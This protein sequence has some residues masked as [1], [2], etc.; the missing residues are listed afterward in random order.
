M[1][2]H[3]LSKRTGLTRKAIEYY[4]EKNLITCA[5]LDNGYR[6]FEKDQIPRLQKISV[7]RKFDLSTEQIRMILDGDEND[8]LQKL[9][10]LKKLR[11]SQEEKKAALLEQLGSRHNYAEINAALQAL[12]QGMSIAQRLL[13]A[14]PGY[15]GKYVCLH[16]A[17][18]LDEP[19]KTLEQQRAYGEILDFLDTLP[20]FEIPA[21]LQPFLDEGLG[22]LTA[23]QIQSLSQKTQEG[24]R[25]P[26]QFLKDNQET[27]H[28]YAAYLQSEEY[29]ASPAYRYKCLLDQFNRTSGY[30]DRFLPAMKRLSPSYAAYCAQAETA[31]RMI[32]E[33]YP[34]FS[35]QVENP[36][37]IPDQNP[38]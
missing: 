6:D 35:E 10:V 9:S 34:E 3:E 2:I 12:E 31:N 20:S 38:G 23:E 25:N 14:F 7:L 4:V 19:V 22:Q 18:F 15:Y 37:S 17:G 28:I 5:T 24:I 32:R 1:L 8:L 27:L 21:D 16:F 29:K 33:Q 36:Q 26:E 30:Y 13:D 11:L